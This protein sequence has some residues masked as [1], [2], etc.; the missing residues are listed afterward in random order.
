[1]DKLF[2]GLIVLFYITIP[3]TIWILM[4]TALVKFIGS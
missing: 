3:V 4:I 2:A 1:M